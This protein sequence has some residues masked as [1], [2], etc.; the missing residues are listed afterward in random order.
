MSNPVNIVEEIDTLSVIPN[1]YNPNRQSDSEFELLCRSIEDDGF[2]QPILVSRSPTE[3]GKFI[4]I[5][6]EH[7]WI[8]AKTLGLARIPAVIVEATEVQ[9]KIAT[10]RF[11]RARGTEELTAAAEVL[12]E[13]S[14][15]TGGDL[16][17]IQD[18]LHMD[19]IELRIMLDD[20][21]T[22]ELVIRDPNAKMNIDQTEAVVAVERQR[23]LEKGKQDQKTARLELTGAQTLQFSYTT[24]EAKIVEQALGGDKP[25]GLLRLLKAAQPKSQ[26]FEDDHE[27]PQD[28][29]EGGLG[30][31][32]K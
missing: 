14:L 8:A 23:A 19:E 29:E 30:E 18:T 6:G 31:S 27:I 2:T 25:A 26:V 3:P 24:G 22:P 32:P 28:S 9:A 4:L 10:L 1:N 15:M 5:D 16:G 11:N 13:I 12:K 20:I 17:L 7:R 21:P